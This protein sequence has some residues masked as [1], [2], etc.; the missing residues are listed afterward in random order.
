MKRKL[1]ENLLAELRNIYDSREAE[2]A[3]LWFH[4]N[5]GAEFKKTVKPLKYIAKNKNLWTA[6]MKAK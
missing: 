1:F 2:K 6:E 5:H 4:E 3:F